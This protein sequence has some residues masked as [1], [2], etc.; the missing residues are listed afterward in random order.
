MRIALCNE[1]LLPMAFE[2]Q[3]ALA[4]GLGYDGLEVAPFTLDEEPHLLPAARRREIRRAAE[5]EGI[6][7]TGLHWLLVT[8]KG[9]SLNGP[10][11]AVRRR[12]L[13]VMERLVGLCADF[14]GRVLVHGSPKQRSIEP[15]DDPA[16]VRARTVEALRAVGRAA[17]AAG[18]VYCL[19]PLGRGETNFVNT[20]AE[21][22]S[23]IDAVGSPAVRT[24][25]DTSAAG[26]TES[27]PVASVLTRWLPSG[28]V[29][30]VQVNDTNRRGPGQGDNQFVPVFRALLDAGYAH[31][32]AVE[33]FRYEPDG[34]STAARAI[35]Y[36]RGILEAIA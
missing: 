15:G 24:M 27:E 31:T 29:A 3:C 14:G 13:D 22:A 10:D 21:A 2:A 30:H 7:I 12:T 1:V 20:V 28:K 8:P 11:A 35:G 16:A 25:V 5:A 4:A 34:Q 19:E 26:Q 36:I 9:L 6:A 33:P 32:V 17:E 18:V 23:I